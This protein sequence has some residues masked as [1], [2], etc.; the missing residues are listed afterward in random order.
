MKKLLHMIALVGL[1]LLMVTG[2]GADTSNEAYAGSEM[3]FDKYNLYVEQT[4]FING[5]VSL[6][7]EGYYSQYTDS[8]GEFTPPETKEAMAVN[9][10]M[11]NFLETIQ[12]LEVYAGQEPSFGEADTKMITLSQ[13]TYKVMTLMN[14]ISTYYSEEKYLEDDFEQGRILHDQLVEAYNEMYDAETAFSL[15]FADTVTKKEEEQRLALK[16]EGLLMGYY[17]IEIL[18]QAEEIQEVFIEAGASDENL[19]DVSLEDYKPVHDKFMEIYNQLVATSQDT[20]QLEKEGL[21]DHYGVGRY[22]EE[23]ERLASA[24]NALYQAIETQTPS[25]D[26]DGVIFET[27][28]DGTIG[29]GAHM[30]FENFY[31]KYQ[32]S[33]DAY[34]THFI[35]N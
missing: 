7:V 4:N 27:N 2:C 10:F 29:T 12:S 14:E 11:D 1:V 5:F 35:N 24:E 20:D 28:S 32:L 6:V 25:T 16:D 22:M 33:V 15:A 26:G 23:V 21:G 19:L 30:Y 31:D 3:E 13:N 9:Y 17:A 18:I 34:N 8:D